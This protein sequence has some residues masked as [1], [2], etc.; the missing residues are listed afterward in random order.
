MGSEL[1]SLAMQVLRRHLRGLIEGPGRETE[2]ISERL[3]KS[4]SE[5]SSNGLAQPSAFSARETTHHSEKAEDN[6][7][8]LQ[9]QALRIMR[10]ETAVETRRGFLTVVDIPELEKRLRLSGWNVERRGNELICWP[11]TQRKPRIQ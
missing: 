7:K 5:V 2:A 10:P 6:S 8:M 3:A 9:S 1:K 11:K 4:S